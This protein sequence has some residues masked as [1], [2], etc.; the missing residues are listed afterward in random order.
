MKDK[1][2][3]N[4]AAANRRSGRFKLQART[5]LGLLPKHSKM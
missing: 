4:S 3:M 2:N 1:V 5:C